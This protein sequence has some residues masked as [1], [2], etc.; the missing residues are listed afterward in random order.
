MGWYG[1]IFWALFML[2]L[3]AALAD[4][5]A[6]L[7]F[8]LLSPFFAIIVLLVLFI[9]IAPIVLLINSWMKRRAFLAEYGEQEEQN[10]LGRARLKEAFRPVVEFK[11]ELDQKRLEWMREQAR[12]TDKVEYR[13]VLEE[14]IDAL[15]KNDVLEDFKKYGSRGIWKHSVPSLRVHDIRGLPSIRELK[16]GEY[17]DRSD[18]ERKIRFML[19]PVKGLYQTGGPDYIAALDFDGACQIL[20]RSLVENLRE[21]SLGQAVLDLNLYTGPCTRLIARNPCPVAEVRH[22][23]RLRG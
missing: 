11:H 16:P 1:T 18:W 5:N 13:K 14:H 2:V 12:T 22:Y 15:S 3:L 21:Q 20:E 8:W 23:E 6:A 17:V 7:V 4:N 10:R 19:V 9:F